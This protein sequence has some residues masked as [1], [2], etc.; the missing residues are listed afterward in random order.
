MNILEMKDRVAEIVQKCSEIHTGGESYFTELDS[1]IK[2][3]DE[4]LLSMI[5]YVASQ[6]EADAIVLSGE[7][8]IRYVQLQRKYPKELSHIHWIIVN[9]GLR[10]GAK[11]AQTF[12]K[13]AIGITNSNFVFLDDSFYSGKTARTVKQY[14]ESNGGSVVKCYCFYDGSFEK[15]IDVISLYR[16]YS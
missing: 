9:G 3:D 1:R 8:G 12:S 13:G 2:S 14:I 5:K 10:K 4:L 15:F 6:K 11:V 16:Y 7:I